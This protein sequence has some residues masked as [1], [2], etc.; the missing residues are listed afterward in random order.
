MSKKNH[1]AGYGLTNGG[2][3]KIMIYLISIISI[4]VALILIVCTIFFYV[5]LKAFHEED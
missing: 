1:M 5:F 3:G 2:N 4:V